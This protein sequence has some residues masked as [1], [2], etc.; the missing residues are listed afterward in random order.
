MN[1]NAITPHFMLFIMCTIDFMFKYYL[2]L[3]VKNVQHITSKWHKIVLLGG[4][5]FN[6]SS[7]YYT[8][9]TKYI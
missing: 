6:F 7:D 2:V 5:Y 4:N 9:K 1:I 8:N 3:K